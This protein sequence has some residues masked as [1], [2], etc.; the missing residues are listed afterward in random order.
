MQVFTGVFSIVVIL[1]GLG[2]AFD[3]GISQL[4]VPIQ[5]GSTG[6]VSVISVWPLISIIAI[7]GA[8][9]GFVQALECDSYHKIPIPF[10][11]RKVDSG[12]FGHVF[13]G[14]FGAIVAISLMIAIFQ[15]ELNP[16]LEAST[17][18][19]KSLKLFFYVAA[20]SVIGGYSGLP[21]ISLVS[22]A[23]L[24]KV[25]HEV[26]SLKKEGQERQ[27]SVDEIRKDSAKIKLENILLRADSYA[28]GEYY[29]E[30][31]KLLEDKYLSEVKDNYKSYNLLAFCEKRN[32]NL[33][34]AME[35]IEKSIKLQPSRLGFY[36]LACYRTLLN[37][38]KS[39]VYDAIVKSWKY[40]E[41][42]KEKNRL[43]SHL[44]NDPD[45]T[46]IKDE[47]KFNNLVNQ[48]KDELNKGDENEY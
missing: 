27:E 3:L 40:A 13:I 5:A 25:Q 37:S 20:I 44:Q 14:I 2:C 16:V 8:S 10:K 38:D 22:N 19:S 41:S 24:K 45:F 35:Y 32:G 23:A 6:I 15:L 42:S 9:G 1:L 39:K 26:N 48:F 17:D 31:I 33:N 28:S 29:A 7:C 36:N 46:K 30:A 47:D 4:I 43:V 11:D 21:I 12:I 34:K 18:I